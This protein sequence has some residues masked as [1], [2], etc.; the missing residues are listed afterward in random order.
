MEDLSHST[1]ALSNN[2]EVVLSVEEAVKVKTSV[3]LLQEMCVAFKLGIQYI[4]ILSIYQ[5]LFKFKVNLFKVY[6]DLN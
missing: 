4:N 2:E 6:Q 5:F 3:S 1:L